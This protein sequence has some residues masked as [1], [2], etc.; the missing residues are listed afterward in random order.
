VD[1]F[2]K[3]DIIAPGKDVISVLSNNSP[4]Y[5]VF[6][7]RVVHEDYFR[8]SGTSMAAPMVTGAV[9]LLLQAEPDLTPD[10]VK[11]RLLQ[12]GSM[13]HGSSSDPNTYPYLDIHA[14]LT[15]LT[16]EA[17]N[18]DII[19]HQLLAKMALMAYW[20]SANGDE[21]I[22]WENVDWDAVNWD[23][24]NWNAVNW[25]AVNWNAVNWNAVNW[26]AVN[27][28]AVNWN[29]VNW[30]SVNWNSVNWNSVNWNSVNWN[31]VNWNSVNW[32]SVDL[33]Y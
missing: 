6:T 28:N 19:P 2:I 32:N 20:S 31:S 4:W 27:W 22:D 10:Q 26:N 7:E 12:T 33:D 15:T 13:I 25:N 3:P 29:A 8:I 9:A 14:A 24:V 18:Q 11:Y 30:N 16:T 5:D 23:A 21:N 1:G 17:A